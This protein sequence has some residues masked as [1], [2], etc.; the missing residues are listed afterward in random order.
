MEFFNGSPEAGQNV[1]IVCGDLAHTT[2]DSLGWNGAAFTWVDAEEADIACAGPLI[3]SDNC[4]GLKHKIRSNE[5]YDFLIVLMLC[6]TLASIVFNSWLVHRLRF[7]LIEQSM[8][9]GVVGYY[10]CVTSNSQWWTDPCTFIVFQAI[11]LVFAVLIG[12]PAFPIAIALARDNW[13]GLSGLWWG[14]AQTIFG[15][16]AVISMVYGYE[17]FAI[18]T[19]LLPI[20]MLA[21]WKQRDSYRVL[22]YGGGVD[23]S[24]D[25]SKFVEN[26]GEDLGNRVRS[27]TGVLN[28]VPTIQFSSA[29]QQQQQ[30]GGVGGSAQHG[31]GNREYS[32]STLDSMIPSD[33]EFGGVSPFDDSA[34]L[35]TG[36]Q[37]G[38][39]PSLPG[40]ADGAYEP[41]P[42]A[43]SKGTI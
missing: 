7:G 35:G 40:G 18:C 38:A 8:E 14:G 10:G 30:E 23:V 3:T 13:L 22:V 25:A 31:E 27:L 32:K 17:L 15:A 24:E 33:A 21:S 16:Q 4:Q 6:A 34:S 9:R 1:G 20:L 12:L 11:A 37:G 39:P 29:Q 43:A 41:S 19:L 2:V 28:Y 5:I 42:F 36:K 26:L